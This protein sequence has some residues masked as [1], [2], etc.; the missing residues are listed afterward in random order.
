[1][2]VLGFSHIVTEIRDFEKSISYYGKLGYSVE[3]DISQVVPDQKRSVLH[4]NPSEVQIYYLRHKKSPRIGVE[5]IKHNESSE[6]K[7]AKNMAYGWSFAD[8]R[9]FLA[10]DPDENALI[11]FPYLGKGPNQHIF[12]PTDKFHET[13]DFYTNIFSLKLLENIS[14][15]DR[16]YKELYQK[17][18]Q[19]TVL[20]LQSC[21]YP[22]WSLALH[23][24][25][26]EKVKEEIHLNETGFSCFCFL[27]N[28][29]GFDYFQKMNLDMV[30]PLMGEKNVKD[31]FVQFRFG[32]IRD[33]NHYLVEYYIP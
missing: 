8:S 25:E 29:A 31:K 5:L 19:S 3:Y 26:T 4:Q 6:G 7:R 17:I 2:T 30:G 24:I 10:K 23:L 11:E 16:Y 27:I 22:N 13:L 14:D 28:Q 32:F 12:L 20:T 21:L 9:F 18:G 33:P 1:M 15:F